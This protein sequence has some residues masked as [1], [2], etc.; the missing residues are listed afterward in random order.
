MSPW[1]IETIIA[2]NIE[3][4]L[5]RYPNPDNRER[6]AVEINAI[7]ADIRALNAGWKAMLAR[8]RAA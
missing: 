8:Q 7:I 5:S 1:Q 2:R 4:I 3:R 6:T